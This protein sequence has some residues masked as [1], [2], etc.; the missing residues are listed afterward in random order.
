MTTLRNKSEENRGTG[1]EAT[2]SGLSRGKRKSRSPEDEVYATS[3]P[4]TKLFNCPTAR[5]LDQV[6][7]VGNME[8]TISM[9]KES[10]NLSYKT[11]EK[12]VKRLQEMG[13]IVPGRRV[14]NASTYVF[15]TENHLSSLI[16]CANRMQLEEIRKCADPIKD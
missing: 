1:G 9:L 10:T 11:V 13:L 7:F 12:T 16:E 6:Q 15:C 8:Q 4:L 14:G 5:I 3:G 2:V